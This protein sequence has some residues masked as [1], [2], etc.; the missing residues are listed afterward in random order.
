M[1]ISLAW[2]LFVTDRRP[3]LDFIRS[4]TGGGL[5]I[6]AMAAAPAMA[7]EDPGAST[8]LPT[9]Q[10]QGTGQAAADTA[11]G[12]I[13]GYVARRTAVGTKTDT[14]IV[15]IPQAISVVGRDQMDD[16]GVVTADEALRYSSG[17]LSAPYGPDTRNDWFFVRGF[18]I[19]QT[20]VYR[21]GMQLFSTGLAGWRV[22]PF[23]LERIDVLKGPASVTF[24]ASAPGGLVN[25]VSKSPTEETLRYLEFGVD[26]N[27]QSFGAYDFSG[28]ATKDGTFLYRLTGRGHF[29]GTMVDN[30]DDAGT[31]IAP[32][33]T[34]NPNQ[35]TSLTVRAQY[36]KDNTQPLGGFLPYTGTEQETVNGQK[37]PR[38][39][40]T[41]DKDRDAYRREQSMIGWEFSHRFND[42]WQFRQNA[43]YNYLNLFYRALYPFGYTDASQKEL[44]RINFKTAPEVHLFT[45][46]NQAQSDFMTGP[47]AHTVLMGVDYRRYHIADDQA[48][49]YDQ[50]FPLSIDNPDYD[51][52]VQDATYQRY[53]LTQQTLDDVGFYLQDQAKITDKLILTLAGRYDV[54]QLETDNRL[55]ATTSERDQDNWSG[56]V[57]VNY[58][59]ESGIAPYAA[60]STFFNPQVGTN[61]SGQQFRAEEGHQYEA[62][63]KY[64]PPGWNATM[65]ASI[66]SLT[67]KNVL[68][69]DPDNSLN[70]IQT[71]EV[72]SNG[73]ELEAVTS[74]MRGL[75][76]IGAFTAMDLEV[77]K[78]EGVDEGKKPVADPQVLA[79]A[80]ADYTHQ[81]G[82]FKGVGAGV[83][84]RYRGQ[85]YADQANEE[86]VDD[87]LL[88][89]A[90]LHYERG[91][92]RVALNVT[93]LFDT[94]YVAAC[95]GINSC[96][97]GDSRRTMLSLRVKW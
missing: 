66:F 80:W 79:S 46:D 31:F 27:G 94:H 50:Q 86:R 47:V 68:T 41:S 58:V 95:N 10:V 78:S 20:G 29:G 32:A 89:D 88:S 26:T 35:D 44:F 3:Y 13:D 37:I 39:F 12:P 49:A 91:A 11:T 73:F 6:S 55:A 8:A 53:I 82:P 77:T 28:K 64:V 16:Q 83:G 9:I 38:D 54:T 69:P 5:A 18:D 40:F 22:D 62:G 51:Q 97:Y 19:T 71:G 36:Q 61:V 72:R 25:M 60:V 63:V 34:W 74:P 81:T 1:N 4:L 96:F 52:S 70:Q 43:A 42:T 7:Q 24:G 33:I 17:V 48:T 56:K 14:P 76:L 65:T 67:R 45:V 92:W 2:A 93:N 75:K 23:S 21:N 30:V 15:E 84:L 85:S 87:V 57:G 90:A 59:F